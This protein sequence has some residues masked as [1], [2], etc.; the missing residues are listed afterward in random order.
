M[1][2]ADNREPSVTISPAEAADLF[3]PLKAYDH[4]AIAVS[5]GPDSV[6]L[7]LLAAE[8]AD[9]SAA[10]LFLTAITVDHGLRTESRAEAEHVAVWAEQ[11]GLEHVILTCDDLHAGSCLQERARE[12]RYT[13]LTSWCMENGAGAVALAHTLDDQAETLLMRLARGSGLDGLTAMSPVS[14]RSG[15]DLVR[16]F[17]K[18]AKSRLLATLEHR[19]HP[20]LD[21]PGNRNEDFERVRVRAAM[22]RLAEIGLTPDALASSASRLAVARDAIEAQVSRAMER[23][24][25]VAGAGVC[26][27]DP[28]VLSGAPEEIAARVLERCLT[29]VGGGR[30]PPARDKIVRLAGQLVTDEFAGATL[31][32]CIVGR[33]VTGSIAVT[34]EMRPGAIENSCVARGRSV[35]WDGRFHVAVAPDGPEKVVVKPLGEERPDNLESDCAWIKRFP[36]FIRRTLTSVWH[37]DRLVGVAGFPGCFDGSGVDVRFDDRALLSRGIWSDM[38]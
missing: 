12:Q 33:L 26:S 15:I 5:G 6:A 1:P 25:R 7:M 13:R 31:G 36:G 14:K 32:G 11:A 35:F 9:A 29:A 4:A 28:A 10:P 20:W 18:I 3:G 34:R 22:P 17:L 30:Y 16:P 38:L 21:D 8:W 27:V 19:G 23:G 24:V 37:E 2:D